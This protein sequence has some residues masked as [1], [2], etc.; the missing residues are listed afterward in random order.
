VRG[1]IK[2]SFRNRISHGTGTR[3]DSTNH[4]LEPTTQTHNAE[5]RNRRR[6]RTCLCLRG[7]EPG[8]ERGEGSEAA[9][10][11][12]DGRERA[13]CLSRR[14]HTGEAGRRDGGAQIFLRLRSFRF[15]RAPAVRGCVG[16]VVAGRRR[17]VGGGGGGR[18]GRLGGHSVDKEGMSPHRWGCSLAGLARRV[19]YREF[20]LLFLRVK[21]K[22]C[23]FCRHFCGP[24]KARSMGLSDVVDSWLLNSRQVASLLDDRPSRPGGEAPPTQLAMAGWK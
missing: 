16:I 12:D 13:Q 9:E 24:K 20:F 17:R 1:F 7:P 4:S 11:G 21:K 19:K 14:A 23:G 10:L 3:L 6:A 2:G 8:R 18:R 5:S 15:V 22:N